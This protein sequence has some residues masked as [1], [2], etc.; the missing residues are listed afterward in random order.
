MKIVEEKD[1]TPDEALIKESNCGIYL[2]KVGP[3]IVGLLLLQD[4]NA[5]KEFYLT[6]VPKILKDLGQ[7]KITVWNLPKEREYEMMQH[8]C[9][10]D[11]NRANDFLKNN[12]I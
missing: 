4:N 8:Y 9:P 6:D 1:C 2:F 5:Q 7:S 3:L 10:E 12:Q 11:L